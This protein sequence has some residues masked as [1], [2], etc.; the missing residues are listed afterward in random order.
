MIYNPPFTGYIALAIYLACNLPFMVRYVLRIDPSGGVI[1][2]LAAIAYIALILLIFF[3]R[4]AT[5]HSPSL[6]RKSVIIGLGIFTVIGLVGMRFIPLE[7]FKVDRWEIINLFWDAVME[8][9]YPYSATTPAGNA[10]GASPVYFLISY[11]AYATGWFEIL[12]LSVPWLWW[13]GFSNLSV[14]TRLR[15]L[16]FL[17]LSPLFIYEIPTRSTLLFNSILIAIFCA[18]M[19]T[20]KDWSWAAVAL[21]G[22]IGG[23]LLNTRTVYG[24]PFVISMLYLL[25]QKGCP[26][27]IITMGVIMGVAYI[28]AFLILAICWSPEEVIADNPFTVQRYNLYPPMFMLIM[29]AISVVAGFITRKKDSLLLGGICMFIASAAYVILQISQHGAYAALIG[30]EADI[31]YF[32]FALPFILPYLT[33]NPGT[34]S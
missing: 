12:P 32:A 30:T 28:G 16:V 24:I 2:G 21:Y 15:G 9:A 23:L 11:P 4:P 20:R 18:R 29:I 14:S 7:A 17:L 34:P 5:P 8:G 19:L 13:F 6:N 22:V 27:K 25:R 33:P 3:R 1:T 31:T 26:F 10:P